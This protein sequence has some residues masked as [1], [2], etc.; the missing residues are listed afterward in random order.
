MDSSRFRL[1][2]DQSFIVKYSNTQHSINSNA[3]HIQIVDVH[4]LINDASIS[5]ISGTI[6][7]LRL[8]QRSLSV[9]Q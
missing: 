2:Q 9:F 6:Y 4:V 1:Y 3:D 5:M 7:F 8:C